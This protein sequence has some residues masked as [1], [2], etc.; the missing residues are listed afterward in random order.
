MADDADGDEGNLSSWLMVKVPRLVLG[1]LACLRRQTRLIGHAGVLLMLVSRR[2]RR[3]DSSKIS[4][5]IV[6]DCIARHVAVLVRQG[7]DKGRGLSFLLQLIR[8]IATDDG[9]SIRLTKIGNVIRK[10]D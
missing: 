9:A 10:R 3:R 1:L 8:S 5:E 2:R 6:A 4:V 7:E